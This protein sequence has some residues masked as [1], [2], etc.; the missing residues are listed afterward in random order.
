MARQ[1]KSRHLVAVNPKGHQT[2]PG[3]EM[4]HG[5][6][7]MAQLVEGIEGD[8]VAIA[9]EPVVV[10][11]SGSIHSARALP[12]QGEAENSWAS[13]RCQRRV[14]QWWLHL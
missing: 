12:L 1:Q 5:A 10:S 3:E 2:D 9:L 13:V 6:H 8:E 4:G 14:N 7:G 11:S